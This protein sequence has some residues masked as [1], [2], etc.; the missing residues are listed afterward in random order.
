MG[1]QSLSKL[2]FI[3]LTRFNV[4]RVLITPRWDVILTNCLILLCS[5]VAFVNCS[6]LLE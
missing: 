6:P 4:S 2:S 5:L 1:L 3:M